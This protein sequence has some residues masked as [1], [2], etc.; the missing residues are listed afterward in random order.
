MKN[1]PKTLTLSPK[2]ART[3]T[4]SAQLAV[5]KTTLSYIIDN[6]QAPTK[7]TVVKKS[8]S[9]LALA[10]GAEDVA[11]DNPAAQVAGADAAAVVAAADAAA[12]AAAVDSVETGMADP[13]L[14]AAAQVRVAPAMKVA[15]ATRKS[16]E[17]AAVASSAVKPKVVRA[18]VTEPVVVAV[19]STGAPTVSQTT[20]ADKLAAI[21][22][23]NYFLPTVKVPGRRG[24]KPSEFTPENDEVAALNAVERAELKAVSKARDRKA[25]GGLADALGGD[26]EATAADLERRRQQI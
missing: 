4:G 8:R 17:S 24:R 23:S 9:R 21:D 3:T 7:V 18:K 11:G 20:D 15:A 26:A 2:A 5:P 14:V 13:A 1:T 12:D 16:S 10:A 22:T 6:E 19:P 25:K